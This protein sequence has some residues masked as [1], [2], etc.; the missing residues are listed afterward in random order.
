MPSSVRISVPFWIRRTGGTE[1]KRAVSV[2]VGE[3]VLQLGEKA[4]VVRVSSE[5]NF[6]AE[7]SG[8]CAEFTA[9]ANGG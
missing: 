3:A 7:C 4:S 5:K 1:Y 6:M 8:F 2:V 9:L